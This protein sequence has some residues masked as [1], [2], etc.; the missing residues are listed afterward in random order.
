MY[1]LILVVFLAVNGAGPSSGSVSVSQHEIGQYPTKQTCSEAAND[2]VLINRTLAAPAIG[3]NF[4]C[5]S[6]HQ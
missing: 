4:I 6:V 1:K 2:A 3:W 5:V